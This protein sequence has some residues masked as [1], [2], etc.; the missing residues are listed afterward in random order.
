MRCLK[1]LNCCVVGTG[2]GFQG[3]LQCVCDKS[4]LWHCFSWESE[5]CNAGCFWRMGKGWIEYSVFV[6]ACVCCVW[7]ISALLNCIFVVLF[8]QIRDQGQQRGEVSPYLAELLRLEEQAKQEG[9]GRWSKVWFRVF[10]FYCWTW[11]IRQLTSMEILYVLVT[12]KINVKFLALLVTW[13]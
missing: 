2:G 5:C 6:F 4:W 13:N 3:W 10:I 9:L 7:V 8:V 1:C 12:V 11:T